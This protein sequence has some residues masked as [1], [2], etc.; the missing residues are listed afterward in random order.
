LAG[1]SVGSTTTTTTKTTTTTT[2][3]DT[4]TTKNNDKTG[5]T[6][7]KTGGT[8]GTGTQDKSSGLNIGAVLGAVVGGVVGGGVG[9]KVGGT[10]G[11]II[12]SGVTSVAGAIV[13]NKLGDLIKD[14]TGKKYATGGLADYTGPAW[15]DGTKSRPELVLNQN[16]TQKLLDTVKV[17]NKLDQATL[18]M[19]DEYINLATAAS[20]ANMYNLHAETTQTTKETELQQQV[21]IT[22]EFP[23]VQDSNEIQDAFDNLINRAAQYIGS[24]R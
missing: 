1:A 23:N 12:G 17:V 22:A 13:G 15:V 16:D 7:G 20:R 6:G 14:K 24:K 11:A 18:T 3:K 10:V 21:H 2:K 4:T 19:M 9:S 8:G 5:G